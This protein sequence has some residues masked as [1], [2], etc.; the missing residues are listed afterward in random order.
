MNILKKKKLLVNSEF[1]QN[2]HM[3]PSAR[4]NYLHV[5]EAV[6]KK[7]NKLEKTLFYLKPE[8]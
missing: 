8:N 5:K 2:I 3:L 6:R 7:E 4:K 1:F